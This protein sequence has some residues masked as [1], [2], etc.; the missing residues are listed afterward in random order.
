MI[1][2]ISIIIFKLSN[3]VENLFQ[4]DYF[5]IQQVKKKKEIMGSI[6]RYFYRMF[7]FLKIIKKLGINFVKE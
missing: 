3:P 6:I 4:Q 2:K 5:Q 7:L 1:V